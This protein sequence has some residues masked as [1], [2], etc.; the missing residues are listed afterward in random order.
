MYR[1]EERVHDFGEE[2]EGDVVEEEGDVV[3]VNRKAGASSRS[4]TRGEGAS[5]YYEVRCLGPSG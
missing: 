2:E 1:G 3:K 4:S 5:N